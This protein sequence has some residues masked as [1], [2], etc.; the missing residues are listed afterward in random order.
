MCKVQNNRLQNIIEKPEKNYLANTGL[1]LV[2]SKVFKLIKANEN[3]SFVDLL[4]KAVLKKMNI[5]VYPIP[6][7]A[8][9]DLGQSIDFARK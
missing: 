7:N 2:N 5:G 3:T 9:I 6:N 8:W 4:N 1:Y